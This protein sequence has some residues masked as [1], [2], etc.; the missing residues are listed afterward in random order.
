[1]A[2]N[3]QEASTTCE[4]IGGGSIFAPESPELWNWTTR[5]LGDYGYIW[6]PYE[7]SVKDNH[8]VH[9]KTGK[10]APPIPW[11]ENQP[12][13]SD[14]QTCLKCK[15]SGC[16]DY[17]CYVKY[18]FA[19]E[20]EKIPELNLRGLCKDTGF[21]Q[22]FYPLNAGKRLIW[23]G[24]KGTL[25]RFDRAEQ[26]WIAKVAG[27]NLMAMAETSLGGLLLGTNKWLVTNDRSC[28]PG[29]QQVLYANLNPCNSNQ[30]NCDDGICIDL[31]K[32]CNGF[33]D[34]SDISDEFNCFTLKESGHYNKD[35][36]STGTK[37]PDKKKRIEVS[38]DVND[39]LD[40][41]ELKEH[42]RI[43]FS[44]TLTWKDERLEYQNLRPHESM[45]SL[46]KREMELIWLP[47]IYYVNVDLTDDIKIHLGP[48]VQVIGNFGNASKT[49]DSS[50]L[51][52][53]KIF[54]G[55]E[56]KLSL[57]TILR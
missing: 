55:Q 34:C 15:N 11:L 16:S 22:V 25:I 10:D 27:E 51:Y 29:A 46:N 14:K 45:N 38:L 54:E 1:M 13:G 17:F 7:D 33:D 3:F 19:C 52:N 23:S 53:A 2:M 44:I 18:K 42:V 5:K 47:E 48:M 37:D 6:S 57:K 35:I 41:N 4:T 40:V 26:K 30:F 32:R 24:T 39:V 21:D 20:F 49:A 8:F 36:I 43:K 50:E 12:D 31:D 28:N 56:S 9:Y